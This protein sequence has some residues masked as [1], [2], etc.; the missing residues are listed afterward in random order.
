MCTVGT[1]IAWD[2]TATPQCC[3]LPQHNVVNYHCT[4]CS[5]KINDQITHHHQL[6]F[7]IGV[8][9]KY[10]WWCIILKCPVSCVNVGCMKLK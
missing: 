6:P 4:N 8:E 3:K 9:D 1:S 2:A 5:L 7:L 10:G